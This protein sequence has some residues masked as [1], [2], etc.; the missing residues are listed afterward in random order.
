MALARAPLLL[1]VLN[2]PAH[3]HI[4]LDAIDLL[5]DGVFVPDASYHIRVGALAWDIA[6]EQHVGFSKG[7]VEALGSRISEEIKLALVLIGVVLRL[8]HHQGN[9]RALHVLALELV[10]HISPL[11]IVLEHHVDEAAHLVHREGRRD[12]PLTY[13]ISPQ[14][15]G[16]GVEA[17]KQGG[18]H[19][20]FQLETLRQ[21]RDRRV[22]VHQ[23]LRPSIVAL[24][25]LRLVGD[26][27]QKLFLFEFNEV[28]AGFARRRSVAVLRHLVFYVRF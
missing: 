4:V 15:D 2:L 3:L 22:A 10:Y 6:L 9:H 27:L 13:G 1:L 23:D 26:A 14:V 7:A 16:L 5:L 11:D 20:E 8:G 17:A 25:H 28:V 12:D 24:I 18:Y 21:R 19:V